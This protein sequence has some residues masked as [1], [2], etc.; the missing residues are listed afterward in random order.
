MGC[1]IVQHLMLNQI[2]DPSDATVLVSRGEDGSVS[3]ARFDLFSLP[4]VGNMMAGRPVVD[5][6]GL[7]ERL[8]GICPVAHHLAGVAALEAMGGPIE[9]T[10]TVKAVRRLLNFGSVIDSYLLGFIGTN[11]AQV[12][13]LRQFAKQAMTVAGS[14]KHFPTTALPGR[15]SATVDSAALADLATA[16]PAALAAAQEIVASQAGVK[17]PDGQ[18]PGADAALVD[19]VGAIDL[20][21]EHLKVVAADGTLI[22]DGVTSDQWDQTVAEAVPGSSA[23]RP[24]LVALGQDN[25]LYRTGPVAQLR[26]GWLT[27]PL[28]E[29]ARQRWLADC[30]GA[31]EARAIIALYCVEAIGQL[32]LDEVIT[33]DDLGQAVAPNGVGVGVGWVESGRGLL[34]H[35]YQCDQDGAVVDATILTP[36]AQNEPWL[37]VL[38]KQACASNDVEAAMED[39]I[40]EADPCLPCST[41]PQGQMGLVITDQP[42]VTTRGD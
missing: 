15:V 32:C 36:T 40:R 13:V 24:Y 38:L 10:P 2:I 9:L 19:E 1:L 29:Q 6:P 7:A 16:L 27:T 26:V 42:A 25:G 22:H 41:A 4:R 14:P 30:G 39:A 12:K 18:F 23:P 37:A 28:A 8:C 11:L 5:V 35:R 34:V 20:V 3:Q 17:A 21:G 31:G 33:L